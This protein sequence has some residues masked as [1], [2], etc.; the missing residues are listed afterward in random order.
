MRGFDIVVVGGGIVGL[1]Q[2]LALKN[3]GLSVAVVDSHVSQGL[4]RGEPEIRVSALTLASENILHNLGVWQH[5]DPKRL[6]S[7]MDMQVW[8][9]DSFGKINFSADQVQKPQLGHIVENQAIRHSLWIQAQN[10]DHIELLAPRQIVQLVFGQQECFITLDDSSQLTAKLV[11][12]ADGANSVVKKHANLVQTFWDYD[13]HAIVATVKT[14]M[15][16]QNTARQIFSATGPLAFLPLWDAHYCSIVW[17]QD[18]PKA[19][20]LLE[21]SNDKFNQALT[22]AFDCTLGLCELV[23]DRQSYPL[24]MRYS[25]QWVANR[26]AII[27]DAAHTIHPLAGQGA[28]LGILDGAALAE[29][30]IKLVAQNKDFGLAKNLRP[31]ERW[32]KTE[33]VKMVAAMEG[34]KRLFAGDQ[35][36]KKL[37]RDTGLSLVNHSSFAKQQIIQHAMG[38]KGELPELA[39]VHLD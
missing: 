28:N 26:V 11:I 3:A 35:P 1:T 12:G 17:S 19:A 22:A 18:E 32:R 13:Q 10:S 14:A 25:R 23:S 36:V 34:F 39:K 21:L 4:P 16:H 5:L 8:D 9:H 30:I 2:A 33:A 15:P 37:I 38:L 7:Y 24:K 27:G 20:E 6:C 31:F 29:Q